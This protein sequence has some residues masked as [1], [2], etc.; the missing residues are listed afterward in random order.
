MDNEKR[1]ELKQ[2]YKVLVAHNLYRR[3]KTDTMQFT[4]AE[5][6][7]AIDT[8]AGALIDFIGV[9]TELEHRA[10]VI[11]SAHSA[12]NSAHSE[13][14][15]LKALLAAHRIPYAKKRGAK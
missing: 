12:L 6:G 14:K 1:E 8:A 3:G 5:L 4:P 9:D 7:D 13:I 15:R 2:A 10:M 11:H